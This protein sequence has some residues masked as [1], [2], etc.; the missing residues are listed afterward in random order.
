[1]PNPSTTNTPIVFCERSLSYLLFVSLLFLIPL[2]IVLISWA[3][4]V[5]LISWFEGSACF[6]TLVG[7]VATLSWLVTV[8]SSCCGWLRLCQILVANLLNASSVW[9]RSSDDCVIWVGCAYILISDNCCP[10][11]WLRM[12]LRAS[13]HSVDLFLKDDFTMALVMWHCPLI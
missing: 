7:Q 3:S 6:W 12:D 1:M 8:R 5:E 11:R 13:I 10:H 4:V 9:L 2:L